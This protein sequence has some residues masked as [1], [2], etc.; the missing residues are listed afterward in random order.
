[1]TPQPEYTNNT[2]IALPTSTSGQTLAVA[3]TSAPAMMT[4]E[5]ANR[6]LREQIQADFDKFASETAEWGTAITTDDVWRVVDA[7]PD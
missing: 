2:A 1:M 4:P 3:Q 6:S 7:K 5:L